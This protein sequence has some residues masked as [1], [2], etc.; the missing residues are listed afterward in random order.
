MFLDDQALEADE[1]DQENGQ[2]SELDAVLRLTVEL[3]DR[4][5]R[6]RMGVASYVLG[7]D[8]QI[9]L[10]FAKRA[11]HVRVSALLETQGADLHSIDKG[12][13]ASQS[14]CQRIDLP[15]Q[16]QKPTRVALGLRPFA[17]RSDAH[18]GGTDVSIELSRN[19]LTF[20]APFVLENLTP[21]TLQVHDKDPECLLV[22]GHRR[23]LPLSL[24]QRDVACVAIQDL[25]LPGS[26]SSGATSL[27]AQEQKMCTLSKISDL[28]QA[29]LLPSLQAPSTCSL[30]T[31][32][33][34][35]KYL[36]FGV[37]VRP[38]AP[39]LRMTKL[40]SFFHRFFVR[41][42]LP[43]AVDLFFSAMVENQPQLLWRLEPEDKPLP[44]HPIVDP[45]LKHKD[46]AQANDRCMNLMYRKMKGRSPFSIQPHAKD[47]SKRRT[48]HVHM[49][50]EDWAELMDHATD[51]SENHVP[52][53]YLQVDIH[54]GRL[55]S[56]MYT[57]YISGSYFVTLRA[58]DFRRS[59]DALF[60]VENQTQNNYIFQIVQEKPA[61]SSKFFSNLQH[62][63]STEDGL[64][65][66]SASSEIHAPSH[67]M[68]KHTILH[69][70]SVSYVHWKPV[71]ETTTDPDDE[72]SKYRACLKVFRDIDV[73]CN[74]PLWSVTLGEVLFREV[75]GK[76]E[77]SSP[78]SPIQK[79]K[80]QLETVIDLPSGRGVRVTGVPVVEGHNRFR[81]LTLGLV[82]ENLASK[83]KT[84]DKCC[85]FVTSVDD[86]WRPA[87]ASIVNSNSSNRSPRG[88]DPSTSSSAG[89]VPKTTSGD[90]P[91]TTSGRELAPMVKTDTARFPMHLG[92]NSDGNKTYYC[93]RNLG[94]GAILG[95]DGICGLHDGPQCSSCWRA[96][97]AMMRDD[98]MR[99]KCLSG[100]GLIARV[101][102]E[103][104]TTVHICDH[105][106]NE[107][108]VAKGYR[109]EEDCDYDL[110]SRCYQ[111]LER[112][113]KCTMGHVLTRN[114]P[115]S[116]LAHIHHY[117]CEECGRDLGCMEDRFTCEQN[118]CDFDLCLDCVRRA[119]IL[120]KGLESDRLFFGQR[121]QLIGV[122]G[123]SHH[124][125]ICDQWVSQIKSHVGCQAVLEFELEV[126]L[127]HYEGASDGV[128]HFVL[129]PLGEQLAA[130]S[131]TSAASSSAEAAGP[132][133][134]V[135][136]PRK[137]PSSIKAKLTMPTLS[138]GWVH[139]GME[140]LAL[141]VKLIEVFVDKK[142][143]GEFAV[144]FRAQHFQVDHF[145]DGDLPVVLNRRLLHINSRWNER[146]ALDI[147]VNFLPA[148][149][150]IKNLK[151]S[152][153]PYWLNLELGV[154]IR[155][156]E[157]AHSS[158]GDVDNRIFGRDFVELKEPEQPVPRGE[159]DKNPAQGWRLMQM[160]IEK[161][162]LTM[163]VRSPDPSSL[164]DDRAL[165]WL[166]HLPVDVP[167]MDVKVPALKWGERFLTIPEFVASL[168]EGY[169]KTVTTQAIQSISLSYLFS[170][171]NGFL[172]GSIWL[173][174]GPGD[175]LTVAWHRHS[176][177]WVWWV[178][179][180][181]HGIAEGLYR[182]FAEVLGNVFF[183]I[184]FICNVSRNMLL[185][186]TRPRAQGIL[187]GLIY[188][189][190]GF[191]LDMVHTPTSQLVK[192]T[193]I[194]Y[195]DRGKMF[196]AFAFGI[197]LIRIPLGPVFGVLCFLACFF[198]GLAN[199]LLHEEAQFAPFE[200]QRNVEPVMPKPSLE[201][202]GGSYADHGLKTYSPAHSPPKISS[203]ANSS[204][205]ALSGP[206][207][208]DDSQ[209]SEWTRSLEG[210]HDAPRFPK[211][212][213]SQTP[214][215]HRSSQNKGLLH[216]L[217][218]QTTGALM[219]A[220]DDE[221]VMD[222]MEGWMR[223]R[224]P[225]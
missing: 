72:Q 117:G 115:S 79:L 51:L 177:S 71:A 17:V 225:S 96:Q 42:E 134:A 214:V 47:T 161:L 48:F 186:A 208:T 118:T 66:D 56:N 113:P 77:G 194:A 217:T 38:A 165:W 15:P 154:L 92:V 29:H 14:I 41:S 163:H 35:D 12:D 46:Q 136:A 180:L 158:F 138:V 104:N 185:G 123:R 78:F 19:T 6:K 170:F 193:R 150:M 203:N 199:A 128:Q 198:E 34:F 206:P 69:G 31:C 210:S 223:G 55:P 63:I 101:L 9:S 121:W 2:S 139:Q 201:D 43:E 109:C 149:H 22:P 144:Q 74:T 85:I 99:P 197:G 90:V 1:V 106:Q 188:G 50:T 176:N 132:A 65:R 61:P 219:K 60:C 88:F 100:H 222:T 57:T 122:L 80:L 54:Q 87:T 184:V 64:I 224:A 183:F 129:R 209:R 84:Q 160:E 49:V 105:C 181:V 221:E 86:F 164:A 174:R 67:A 127:I 187:E 70:A 179:P 133:A 23:V 195:Q 8:G 137:K 212:E 220:F 114:S 142:S 44:L 147:A 205:G 173:V 157:L 13:A 218:N 26:K 16:T 119:Q 153:V 125:A 73:Q 59:E 191:F 62:G 30:E 140:K 146:H 20:Y 215:G 189:I 40:I 75:Q 89:D 148:S 28:S 108:A 37:C 168:K 167:N 124:K 211:N 52:R 39:P 76:I 58:Q 53:L 102:D 169:K 112:M 110:C 24:L 130:T 172:S 166:M 10:P 18:K 68:G 175:A 107:L 200:A 32:G 25:L 7:V 98:L 207:G 152:L 171:A 192:Q 120:E 91:Q 94:E 45:S 178:S 141:R 111:K 11:L 182:F 126:E 135:A 3:P 151:I 162:R 204:F 116:R 93:G 216:R 145:V 21:F 202:H 103:I 213:G 143:I 82:L 196:A 4:S 131:P 33:M 27:S 156:R 81:G 159:D 83:D 190:R 97:Q 95:S 155:L 36:S 5:N